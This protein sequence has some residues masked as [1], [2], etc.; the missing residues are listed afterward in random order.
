VGGIVVA[1]EAAVPGDGLEE[2]EGIE[3]QWHNRKL[4]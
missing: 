2:A 3:V 4:A 1:G